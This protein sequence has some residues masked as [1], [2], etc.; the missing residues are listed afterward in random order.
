LKFYYRSHF[1]T[2]FLDSDRASPKICA[3]Q[4]DYLQKLQTQEQQIK[5]LVAK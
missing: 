5:F 4:G 1:I 2:L 3:F